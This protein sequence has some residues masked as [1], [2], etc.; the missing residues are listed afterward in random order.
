MMHVLKYSKKNGITTLSEYP[1]YE[2][3]IN[4]AAAGQIKVFCVDKPPALY[5][6]HK[7]HLEDEYRYSL[8]LYTGEL[9]RA[10]RKGRTALLDRVEQGF[11]EISAAEYK[12]IDE[13]WLGSP[14]RDVLGIKYFL[15]GAALV[16]ALILNLIYL[17]FV[18]RRKVKHKTAELTET[19]KS[20]RTS[21]E[22]KRAFISAI[23]DMMFVVTKEGMFVDYNSPDP[24]LVAF[25]VKEFI[26]KDIHSVPFEPGFVEEAYML[27][28]KV[29]RTK[30]I[31]HYVYM[32]PLNDGVKHTFEA[33]I[34]PYVD[35]S[36]IWI[37]RDITE[38]L[39]KDEQ[40][41]Q[42]QKMET[43]GNLAGGLA[44]DFNNVLGGII[45]TTS[46]IRFTIEQKT[47]TLEDIDRDVAT[48]EKIAERGS[49]IVKQLLTV[50]RRKELLF[51]LV[52]LNQSV[53]QVVQ[54]CRTTFDKSVSITFECASESAMISADR[55]NIEQL[56]L[57]L[58]INGYHAMTIMRGQNEK[59]GGILSVAIHAVQ[60]D[61]RF[62]ALHPGALGK[63]VLCSH[64]TRYRCRNGPE[65]P[66]AY[67]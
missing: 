17:N 38:S 60:A 24:G 5:Y 54:I 27:I 20:L 7:M 31:E 37:S 62:H 34:V 11:A 42:A 28:Q 13:K 41:L 2:A 9:H 6:L 21:E 26:G 39:R 18:L 4:A 67:V 35:D 25:P 47:A 48:I 66:V 30:T 16:A 57:N 61:E 1:G 15:Y 50:T 51:E 12:K 19:I 29:S 58:C 49:D 53:I 52:D 22:Q 55:T 23:P 64:R 56:M 33:R 10:V 63:K 36:I 65:C 45:G 3:V 43:V 40:L 32:L 14:L 44:H 8:K 59:M 46:L